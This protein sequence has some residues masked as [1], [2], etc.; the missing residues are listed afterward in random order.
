MASDTRPAGVSSFECGVVKSDVGS[1]DEVVDL[2]T[3]Q[4]AVSHGT[5]IGAFDSARLYRNA[6]YM[7]G[8]SVGCVVIGDNMQLAAVQNTLTPDSLGTIKLSARAVTARFQWVL[9]V[10]RAN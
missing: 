8:T 6:A 4:G 3:N 1:T 5:M 2:E 10:G 9:V 7:T